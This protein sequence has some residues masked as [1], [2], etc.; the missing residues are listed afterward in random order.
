[1]L[2]CYDGHAE[3]IDKLLLHGAIVDLKNKVL[4][5]LSERPT[6]AA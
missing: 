4:C 6:S 5:F 2:A 1:M 3:I